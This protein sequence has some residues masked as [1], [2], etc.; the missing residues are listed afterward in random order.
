MVII[1]D[2]KIFDLIVEYLNNYNYSDLLFEGFYYD[3]V[4]WYVVWIWL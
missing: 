1:L 4:L 2:N 3:I